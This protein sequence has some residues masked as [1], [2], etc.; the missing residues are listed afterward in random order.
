MEDKTVLLDIREDFPILKQKVHGERL[1]YLDNAA[2]TLK[3]QQVVEAIQNHYLLGAS[4]VHR[5]I[6]YLSE[7]ATEAYESTRRQLKE[8]IGA[9]SS[10]EI[11]FTSGTTAAINLVARS[12]ASAFLEPGDEILITEM[13]HHSNIVPWQMVAEDK[14]AILKVVPIN[15]R[16][17]LL[18]SAYDKLLGAKTK[19]VA[20]THIS[21][22]LGTVNPVSAIIEKAHALE[23]P[24]LLDCAQVMAHI[25]LDVKAL[26]VD[27]L[28]FSGHKMFGPT[29][30]GV[31]YGKEKWLEKMPP[32]FGG[33]DM[34]DQVTL[35]KT[36][37][38][39]L[40]HKFEA[41]T[42]HIA[43]V[44]GLGAAIQ[45]LQ[46]I[47]FAPIQEQER[48]LLAYGTASL[49]EIE[50]LTLIGTATKK[51]A[52][53]AFVLENIHPHDLGTFLDRR[54]VAIRTGHHC[55]Q[56]IMEHYKVPATARSSFSCYNNREDID[57]LSHAIREAKKFFS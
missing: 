14:G 45:Y 41:G 13:E 33:G 51:S 37:Y 44:L 40:P 42:P 50:G 24:V 49:Q 16:G 55:T 3:P 18:L 10:D 23:V 2:T 30:I 43:G 8:F 22:S 34:I 6:H 20:L 39:G 27:F 38:A 36:T 21:N 19:I 53:L 31:L 9:A 7:Q 46:S 47:G 48:E 32:L 26:D 5:G 17:E 15:D 57:Q 54:G 11:I 52:I 35:S 56:P 29:G 25:P 4:N 12:F 28:A 1:A